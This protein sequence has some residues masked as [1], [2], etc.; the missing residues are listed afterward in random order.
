M[1]QLG[2][3]SGRL[4]WKSPPTSSWIFIALLAALEVL[5]MVYW[6][7]LKIYQVGG[8]PHILADELFMTDAA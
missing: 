8:G 4:E 3:V 6:I 5:T 2:N 7:R 1:V